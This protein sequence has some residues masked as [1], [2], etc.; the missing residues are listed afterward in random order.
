MAIDTIP[1]TWITSWTAT[2]TDVTFPIASVDLLDS[3]EANGTTGDIRKVM[4]ALCEHIY[5]HYRQLPS[6]DKP[7]KMILSKSTTLNPDT[8]INTN[9]YTFRFLT[10]VIDEDVVAEA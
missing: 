7:T 2:A 9:T 6:G 10:Q 5:N 3:I 4:F 8:N 1:E